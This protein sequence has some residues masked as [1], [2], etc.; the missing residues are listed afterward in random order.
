M[1][2]CVCINLL[3]L[4]YPTSLETVVLVCKIRSLK[5]V[6]QP[7]K[8]EAPC[9]EESV[10]MPPLECSLTP[11]KIPMELLGKVC[12]YYNYHIWG[13]FHVSSVCSLLPPCVFLFLAVHSNYF[14]GHC[15]HLVSCRLKPAKNQNRPSLLSL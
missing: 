2:V 9:M 5:A 1:Y 10:E 12:C 7:S 13:W 4:F 11:V 3:S 6:T 8:S 15:C 14:L